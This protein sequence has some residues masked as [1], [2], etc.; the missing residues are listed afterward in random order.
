M[1]VPAEGM[2][3]TVLLSQ[4]H[5]PESQDMVMKIFLGE[6]EKN[7]NF[8]CIPVC[9]NHFAAIWTGGERYCVEVSEIRRAELGIGRA[10]INII[11]HKVSII[12]T[13]TFVG[14]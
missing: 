4:H 10:F 2:D 5:L 11:G 9:C 14:V 13:S 1:L 3:L 7:S 8:F 12:V 6:G